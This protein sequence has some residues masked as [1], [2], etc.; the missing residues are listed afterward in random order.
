MDNISI[1][2]YTIKVR[3]SI[4]EVLKS[5][6][7]ELKIN[8]QTHTRIPLNAC[9]TKIFSENI[10][11][12]FASNEMIINDGNTTP[13]VAT[14]AP[15]VPFCFLPIKVAVFTAITPGVHCEMAK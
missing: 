9:S 6:N 7:A 10:C 2:R 4:T 3:I 12:T 13:S 11:K 5:F 1:A 14:M 8:T 15:I